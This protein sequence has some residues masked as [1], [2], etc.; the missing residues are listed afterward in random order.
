MMIPTADELINWAEE[1]KF[2][3]RRKSLGNEKVGCA[4]MGILTM[5]KLELLSMSIDDLNRLGKISKG[6][7]YE[8]KDCELSILGTEIYTKAKEKGLLV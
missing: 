5:N 7:E 1:T 2:L 8:I 3:F 4:V 6:F